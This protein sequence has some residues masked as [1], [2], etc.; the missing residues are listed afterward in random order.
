MYPKRKT[1]ETDRLTDIQIAT[2]VTP[3]TP[4]SEALIA[5]QWRDSVGFLLSG[6]SNL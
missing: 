2:Q 1:M 4:G 5:E 3:P 6:R